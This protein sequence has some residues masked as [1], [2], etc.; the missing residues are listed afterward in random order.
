M[1][2]FSSK[3]RK[4]RKLLYNAPLHRR[5]RM[6][7]APLSP[8]LQAKYNLR[9]FPVRKGDTVRILRGDYFGVEGKITRVDSKGYRIYIE[10]VT[11]E[12][13]D[14]TTVQVPVTP[15]KIT[16]AKLNLEDKWRKKALKR[17][18][19]VPPSPPV[20][21]KTAKAASHSTK[22]KEA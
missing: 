19:E 6:L 16:L 1:A 13:T 10:G 3:P 17:R 7:A 2:R 22:S 11:K 5:H 8:E 14:G 21:E 4:Q 20:T 15:S 9:S 18:A 12:K